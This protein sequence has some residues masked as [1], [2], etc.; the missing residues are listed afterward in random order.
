[1]EFS[2]LAGVSE[3]LLGLMVGNV[4]LPKHASNVPQCALMI[5]EIVLRAGFPEGAFQTLLIGSDKV[6]RILDG[7]ARGGCNAL[8]GGEGAGD[9][10]WDQ[11]RRRGSR[12]LCWGENL[13]AATPL[14]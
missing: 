1:M 9:A 3:P 4:D 5:E 14:S 7:S 8:T 12:K 2:I 6:D 11:G 13:A 10:S